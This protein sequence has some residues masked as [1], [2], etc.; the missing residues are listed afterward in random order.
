MNF[1]EKIV[2]NKAL[3]PFEKWREAGVEF[4]MEQYT[5]ENCAKAQKVMDDLLERLVIAGPGANTERRLLLIKEAVISFN[6][7]NEEIDGL[8]ETGEREDLC[9]LFDQIAISVDID[10][11]DYDNDIASQWREW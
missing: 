2:A 5:P 3:Y 6:D 10:P 8:I 4:E 7:L 11:A 1:E 9:D